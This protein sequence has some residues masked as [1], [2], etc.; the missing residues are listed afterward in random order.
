MVI[1]GVDLHK[2]T[3]TAVAVDES[4]RKLAELTVPAS[5]DGHL[6]LL[7]WAGRW[8]ERRWAL[9]DCRHLSRRLETDLLRA[10]EGVVRV[11]PKLM[12]GV[13]MSAREPGKS[14]P[15]DALAVAR[16]AV[17]EPDLPVATLDEPA[18]ELR[19]LVDHREDLVAE[20]TREMCRLRWFLVELGVPE[21]PLGSLSRGIVR[22]RLAD[23]LK[24]RA[25]P[26][27]RFARHA[28]GR[29]GELTRLV[30][31][32]ERE[33]STLVAPAAPALLAIPGCGP[34]TAAKLLGETAGI[35][36]FHSKDRRRDRF[37]SRR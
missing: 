27:A 25:E 5:P 30:D 15:I 6:A 8:P 11:P 3:H 1:V 29:I 21:P 20:R 17:R 12:A 4:G 26:V 13:R 16:A 33:I 2:R 7:R 9:E 35:G 18:R 19:L 14:D 34:L 37:A 31:E 10:G 32:L 23:A 24:H 36:R 28:L 22:A